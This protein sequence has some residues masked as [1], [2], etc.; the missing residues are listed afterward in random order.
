VAKVLGYLLRTDLVG[1]AVEAQQV[2]LQAYTLALD[3]ALLA[4]GMDLSAPV[5]DQAQYRM[6]ATPEA[7][8]ALERIEA[9]DLVLSPSPPAGSNLRSDLQ[10]LLGGV[11]IA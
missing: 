5:T 9:A 7:I 6:S 8:A 3:T 4:L 2:A 10:T 1:Q 11:D